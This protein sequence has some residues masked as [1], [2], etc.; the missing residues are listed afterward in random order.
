MTKTPSISKGNNCQMASF[1]YH[2]EY[3]VLNSD[4]YDKLF[5]EFSG[6]KFYHLNFF[7][8]NFKTY[9]FHK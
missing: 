2:P 9:N 7:E 6:L 4:I 5:I 1:N 3:I 8:K